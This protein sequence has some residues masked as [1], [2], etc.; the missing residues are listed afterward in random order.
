MA[1]EGRLHH[2]FR[3]GTGKFY[4]WAPQLKDDRKMFRRYAHEQKNKDEKRFE[5]TRMTG[6]VISQDDI[7]PLFD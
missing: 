2:K 1:N 5:S 6:A 4:G 7:D 3:L